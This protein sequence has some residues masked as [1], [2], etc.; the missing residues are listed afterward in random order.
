MAVSEVDHKQML[1]WAFEAQKWRFNRCLAPD[2]KCTAKAIQAHSIQN[3]RVLDLLA[4]DGHVKKITPKVAKGGA[5][6]LR[7]IIL[8][9]EDVGRNDAA[10]FNGFCAQ[11]DAEIFRPIDVKPLCP[12]DPEQ[13]FLLAYRAITRE[14][15][16]LLEGASKIQS[17]Y[18]R[19][20]NVGWDNGNEPEPAGMAAID[21]MIRAYGTY[22]YRQE[23]DK[24]LLASQ[25]GKVLHDVI[26]LHH[27]QPTIAVCSL[28]SLDNIQ[29]E[30]DWLRV[31]LNVV[32]VSQT[33]SFAVFSYLPEDAPLARA[34]LHSILNSTDHYQ[35]Y[36]LSRLV[37]N[38]C[39]NFVISPAYYDTWTPAKRQFVAEYFISTVKTGNLDV[40]SE[41]L[42]LF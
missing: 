42:Y 13:L 20:I 9:F 2:M 14:L 30:D 24:A 36:A 3:G 19:R 38:N 25:H 34:S 11:H 10:T 39:E 27:S 33:D 37:L 35:K 32:P 5:Q 29:R 26:E 17:A 4:R 7:P 40:E 8:D 28:F 1:S 22:L 21:H 18:Q 23:F 41:H 15:H 16:A 31:A 12:N 6:G